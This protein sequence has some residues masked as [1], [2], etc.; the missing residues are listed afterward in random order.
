MVYRKFVRV[1]AVERLPS[2]AKRQ[3]SFENP[4]WATG[5]I[6]HAA[7]L[8]PK[9]T[10]L[11]KTTI[12]QCFLWFNDFVPCPPWTRMKEQGLWDPDMVSWFYSSAKEPLRKLRPLIAILRQH[13]LRVCMIKTNYPGKIV[14]RDKIQVVAKS[15]SRR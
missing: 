7:A 1:V 5:V 2:S 15:S 4:W 6:T 13:G 8:R 12:N 10:K 11:E 3:R 14:Y 9:L